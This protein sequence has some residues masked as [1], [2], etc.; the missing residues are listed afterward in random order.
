MHVYGASGMVHHA[1]R[2]VSRPVPTN[3][4]P[5]ACGPTTVSSMQ[6][7]AVRRERKRSSI[8]VICLRRMC[9]EALYELARL[10]QDA[11]AVRCCFVGAGGALLRGEKVQKRNNKHWASIRRFLAIVRDSLYVFH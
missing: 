11:S 4:V 10:R 7:R 3:K 8:D 5:G 2:D 1:E 6:I 9:V